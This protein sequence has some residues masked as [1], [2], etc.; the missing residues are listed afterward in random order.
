MCIRDRPDS[1][2]GWN[3]QLSGVQCPNRLRERDWYFLLVHLEIITHSWMQDTTIPRIVDWL[4]GWKSWHKRIRKFVDHIWRWEQVKN[5]HRQISLGQRPY[6]LQ[7]IDGSPSNKRIGSDHSNLS[8]GHEIPK[9]WRK[10]V[11]DWSLYLFLVWFW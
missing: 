9:L 11:E 10:D 5:H 4:L 6:F 8:S 7:H 3:R 1:S 2:K